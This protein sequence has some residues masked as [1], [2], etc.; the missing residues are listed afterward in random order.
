M[1]NLAIAALVV[2]G[3]FGTAQAAGDAA[4]GKTKAA[5]CAS[6][7][8][9]D[10]NSMVPTFPKLAG[11]HESY[12]TKQLADFKSGA[13]VDP[14][15]TGMA[16]PLSDQDMAD[17][18]AYFASQTVAIGSA[19]AEKAAAGKKLYLGGNSTKGISA[20]MA[21]HGPNGAGNP[22]AKFPALQGQQSMY[23]VKQLQDFRSGARSNDTAKIMPSI[24][25]RM[26]DAEIE[27]VA[28]YI[29][30]LH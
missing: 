17:L 28:E 9:A 20:C 10:G 27:A 19:N 21:C 18:S 29:A 7:H 22:G 23:T 11:Q 12:L 15:M 14:T 16:M 30:G 8:G 26:S 1:K 25:A 6:C 5:V 3:A 13:R 24:A 2:L 4:A